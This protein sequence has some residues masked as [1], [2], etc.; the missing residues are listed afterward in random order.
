MFNIHTVGTTWTR[1]ATTFSDL[2]RSF[3]KATGLYY[4]LIFI[5]QIMH[6]YIDAS[7]Y[8]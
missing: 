4:T 1:R 7:I 2:C 6:L 5:T 8:A 3:A